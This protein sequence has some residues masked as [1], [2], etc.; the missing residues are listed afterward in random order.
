M[1]SRAVASTLL[2][3]SEVLAEAAREHKSRPSPAS[4]QVHT[5]SENL[6]K[7]FDGMLQSIRHIGYREVETAGAPHKSA[8]Q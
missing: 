2:L 6:D 7:D 3:S 1:R 8:A 5:A 4:V